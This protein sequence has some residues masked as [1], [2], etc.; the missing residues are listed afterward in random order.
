[1]LMNALRF[2]TTLSFITLF[3][4]HLFVSCSYTASSN[5]EAPTDSSGVAVLLVDTDH[6][7]SNVDENIYGQF[8]EHIN[9][10]VEDGL[11]AEQ[12][13]GQGFEG[14]DFETYWK[15]IEKNGN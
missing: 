14:K 1:M 9:H 3:L 12:A 2:T 10:S 13:Q 6:P 8:L 11:Y 15:P 7:L 5:K 4:F